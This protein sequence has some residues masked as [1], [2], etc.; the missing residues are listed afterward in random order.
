MLVVAKRGREDEVAAILDEVG[1]HRGRDRRSDRR[2]GVSRDRRRSRRRRVPRHAARHRLSDLHARRA[3][4]RRR[5]SRCARATSSAIAERPEERDPLWTL[6][7]TALVADDR[8]QD[9]GATGSTTRPF[10]RT[11]S[12]GPGGDAAVV[13][14]RGTDRALALQDR[15]QRALRLPR[16]ARRRADRRCEAA[17]NVACTG[18]RPMAITNN[19]EL[20]QSAPARGLLPA[21]RGGRAEWRE[22]CDA[23]G[24][25]VTGGN[26]SLYNENPAAPCIP[27]RSIGMVGA[28][29]VARAHDALALPATRATRS[30][31]SAS[32]PLE[33][34]RQRVS[35]A[36]PRRRRRRAAARAISTPSAR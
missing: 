11:R 26:V 33:H 27:R 28:H 25:P 20:R 2:A 12:I 14:V 6:D 13:R 29:R 19:L 9:V 36:H 18:A 10:A 21:A 7:A 34:R 32:R 22:A 8:D 30:S 23:L 1:P 24:T 3:G 31:C 17:R 15:L 4:E 16:S 5:S 35:R